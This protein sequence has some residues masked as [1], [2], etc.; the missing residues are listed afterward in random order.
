ME[1]RAKNTELIKGYDSINK[2]IRGLTSEAM[3]GDA[4]DE[5][6]ESL[7]ALSE[8]YTIVQDSD[9]KNTKVHLKDS[10]AF[11]NISR[12]AA[13]NAQSMKFDDVG[14]Q[15]SQQEFIKNI[16]VFLLEAKGE[17]LDVDVEDNNNGLITNEDTFNQFN[18][19]QMGLTYQLI[20]RKALLIDH[21]N[22]PLATE[23]RV[24]QPR[25]RRVDD[26]N[27]QTKATTARNVKASEIRGD[28]EQNTATMVQTTYRI[29]E[30]RD[31]GRFEA[32][33]FFKFF[34]NPRSFSQS[35]EN[36][37]FTS[38]LIK[39]GKLRLYVEDDIPMIQML[40]EQEMQDARGASN[41]PSVH[42]ISS[43]DYK[44][45]QTLIETFEITESF[46]SHRDGAEDTIPEED[47][48]NQSDQNSEGES[49][50]EQERV[51]DKDADRESELD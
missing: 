30:E 38:F 50:Q 14:L 49:D 34:I 3:K 13:L 8:L 6:S 39:E 23:K 17:E 15:L 24:M 51:S 1:N 20:S 40:T 32:V 44:T 12:L 19:L 21:L 31:Q 18:W 22:G 43:L 29:F 25:T 35:I 36:L 10:E 48:G 45:W 27:T 4:H 28:P 37:F 9:V 41:K 33:N 42:Q 16:K 26:S 7:D 5:I 11:H 46:L 2:Q 47:G